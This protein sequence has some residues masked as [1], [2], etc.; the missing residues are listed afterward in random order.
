MAIS[1]LIEDRR[2]GEA[3]DIPVCTTA[4]FRTYWVQAA[5]A[6]RL[7]MIRALG[8]LS[9]TGEF[10]PRFIAELERVRSW[11]GRL[12]ADDTYKPEMT[13]RIDTIER[14][15]ATHPADAYE[16]SFG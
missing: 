6:E 8:A 2:T 15:L 11:A 7:D 3:T 1:M 12:P 14:A 16:V 13:A 10:R 9:L 4:M 5:Q